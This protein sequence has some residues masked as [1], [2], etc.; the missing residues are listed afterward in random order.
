MQASTDL[1]YDGY[2][3]GIQDTHAIQ[4]QEEMVRN[5]LN[6]LYTMIVYMLAVSLILTAGSRIRR[7][8]DAFDDVNELDLGE[9][10]TSSL[11]SGDQKDNSTRKNPIKKS[12]VKGKSV[13]ESASYMTSEFSSFLERVL[14]FLARQHLHDGETSGDH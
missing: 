5:V 8:L 14:V 4:M 3:P 2:K 9:Q 12:G 11:Y 10:S 7:F 1:Y 13:D 6:Y